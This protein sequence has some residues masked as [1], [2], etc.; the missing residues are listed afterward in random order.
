MRQTPAVREDG[1]GLE[2][3]GEQNG[4]LLHHGDEEVLVAELLDVVQVLGFPGHMPGLAAE[5]ERLRIESVS[6]EFDGFNG[7]YVAF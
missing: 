7:Y 1:R 2:P 5:S 6:S 4:A 3:E